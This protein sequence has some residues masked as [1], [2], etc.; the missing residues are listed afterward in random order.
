VTKS[1]AKRRLLAHLRL[2]LSHSDDLFPEETLN[3]EREYRPWRDAR[4]ELVD[5]FARRARDADP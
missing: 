4:D 1:E 5:E 3:S 2:I